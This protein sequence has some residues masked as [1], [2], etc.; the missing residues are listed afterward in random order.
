MTETWAYSGTRVGVTVDIFLGIRK[1]F[2]KPWKDYCA[3]IMIGGQVILNV[4][5]GSRDP[6]QEMIL[7]TLRQS[8]VKGKVRLQDGV[9]I[10]MTDST[11][12]PCSDFTY[13]EGLARQLETV[14]FIVERPPEDWPEVW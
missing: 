10:R 8:G 3:S 13:F 6:L 4:K 5:S 1:P 9:R 2:D 7:D 14:G 12:Q 11:V